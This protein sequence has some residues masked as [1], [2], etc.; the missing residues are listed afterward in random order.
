MGN[1]EREGKQDTQMKTVLSTKQCK[2]KIFTHRVRDGLVPR[3]SSKEERGGGSTAS[4]YG[5]AVAMELAK[6]Q[7]FEVSCW[8]SANWRVC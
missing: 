6:S 1:R 5:L 2:H 3:P 7:A 8:A 4:H